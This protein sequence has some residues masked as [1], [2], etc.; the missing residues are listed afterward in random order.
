MKRHSIIL[1]THDEYLRAKN[2][3]DDSIQGMLIPRSYN[4]VREKY[5]NLIQAC[6]L[7][8]TFKSLPTKIIAHILEFVKDPAIHRKEAMEVFQSIQLPEDDNLDIYIKSLNNKFQEYT[9]RREQNLLLSLNKS[10]FWA[11]RNT[12]AQAQHEF[13][14]QYGLVIKPKNSSFY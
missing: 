14:K 5:F 9:N 10:S 8:D 12:D 13:D 6:F 1:E 11:N 3:V 2:I 4:V 7:Q